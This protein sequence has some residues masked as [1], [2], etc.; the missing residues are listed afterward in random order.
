MTGTAER[1]W[2][3]EKYFRKKAFKGMLR[4]G[5]EG[6][7][8]AA[9][10]VRE[11]AAEDPLAGAEGA[12]RLLER[13]PKALADLDDSS[14]QIQTAVEQTTG[15][16]VRIIAA[17]PA[18]LERREEWLDRLWAAYED[19]DAW[20]T[21]PMAERWGELCAGEEL[22]LHW[23]EL[24]AE[25]TEIEWCANP[26]RP[27]YF[28]GVVIGLSALLAAGRHEQ[29]LELLEL[30]PRKAWCCRIFGVKALAAMGRKAEALEYAEECR[31]EDQYFGPI[32]E[33]CEALLLSSGFAEE[34]YERYGLPANEKHTYLGTFRAMVAKYPHKAPAE[35]LE[36]LVEF[37]TG[38][39]GHWFAAALHAG[40]HDQ[41]LLLA[42][43]PGADP[44]TLG[45]AAADHVETHPAFA[46]G[47]GRAALGLVAEGR[48]RGMRPAE[49]LATY[50][51]VLAAAEKLGTSAEM[52]KELAALAKED[53]L[54]RVLSGELEGAAGQGRGSA[55]VKSKGPSRGPARK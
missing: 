23:G 8:K 50:R 15:T 33:V 9:R 52:R 28:R 4:A 46:A 53:T 26:D 43:R 30:E 24:F 55:R 29:I 21:E 41:A 22:A 14:S 34:A 51:A 32:A 11:A 49:I 39:E 18:D 6:L 27:T 7:K 10:E 48:G 44:R 42:T 36:D 45:R 54:A 1:E 5:I 12:V 20:W 19:D 38:E 35:I 31:R 40:L 2:A 3:F 25:L 16:L 13:F 47:V 17:A 37:T